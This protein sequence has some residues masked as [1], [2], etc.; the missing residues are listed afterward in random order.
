MR[1]Q[2][3]KIRE[4]KNEHSKILMNTIFQIQVEYQQVRT[5]FTSSL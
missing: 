2:K 1:E 5:V 3:K 4:Y